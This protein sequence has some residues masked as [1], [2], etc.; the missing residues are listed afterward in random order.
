M[1]SPEY[2]GVGGGCVG[3]IGI[4]RDVGPRKCCKRDSIVNYRQNREMQIL[5]YDVRMDIKIVSYENNYDVYSMS[6]PSK[7]TR[8]GP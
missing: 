3:D 5:N 6:R 7:V 8:F 2:G 1:I 4:D